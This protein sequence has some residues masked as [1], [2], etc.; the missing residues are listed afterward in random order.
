MLLNTRYMPYVTYSIP[1]RLPGSVTAVTEGSCT[2]TCRCFGCGHTH[3]INLVLPLGPD[4]EHP[5]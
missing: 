2:Q 5:R 4:E 1:K 3:G